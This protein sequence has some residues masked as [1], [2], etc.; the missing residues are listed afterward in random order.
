MYNSSTDLLKR[1]S[2]PYIELEEFYSFIKVL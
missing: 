1:D 2:F